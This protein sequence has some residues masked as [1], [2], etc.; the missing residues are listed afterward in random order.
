MVLLFQR[1]W[2]QF[3]KHSETFQF[4]ITRRMSIRSLFTY[5]SQTKIKFELVNPSTEVLNAWNVN[6]HRKHIYLL[7][8]RHIKPFS[9]LPA[10]AICQQTEVFLRQQLVCICIKLEQKLF[11]K[12]DLRSSGGK[13]QQDEPMGNNSDYIIA[14]LVWNFPQI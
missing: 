7:H 9:D 12:R 4:F 6:L 11:H 3:I 5:S 10:S 8:V 14:V 1:L 13:K 2:I